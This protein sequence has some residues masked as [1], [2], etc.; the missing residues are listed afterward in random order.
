MWSVNNDDKFKEIKEVQSQKFSGI[1]IDEHLNW[2][3]HRQT[4][5]L[6]K[7]DFLFIK[8]FS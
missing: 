2:Y 3:T 4:L 1:T 8:K 5:L 6:L 7:I